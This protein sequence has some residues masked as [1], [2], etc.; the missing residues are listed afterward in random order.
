VLPGNP[1]K[2]TELKSGRR[3]LA[4]PACA[5]VATRRRVKIIVAL[6][7]IFAK[8]LEVAKKYNL[9]FLNEN[10]KDFVMNFLQ[11]N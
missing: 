8:K 5:A 10:L 3:R 9:L 11:R 6:P 4:S 7:R 2:E 1:K